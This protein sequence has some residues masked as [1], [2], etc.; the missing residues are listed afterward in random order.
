[1]HYMISEE[2]YDRCLKAY[3]AFEDEP[4]VRGSI[5]PCE[6][7]TTSSYINVEGGVFPMFVYGRLYRLGE[8]YRRPLLF[9]SRGVHRQGMVPRED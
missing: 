2:T 8:G 7:S 6:A 5:I 4:E 1:M 3:R 9:L